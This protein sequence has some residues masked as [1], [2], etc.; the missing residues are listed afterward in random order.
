MNGPFAGE[1]KNKKGKNELEENRKYY[2][3]TDAHENMQTTTKF[4]NC[5]SAD[6]GKMKLH[7]SFCSFKCC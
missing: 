3:R 7:A 1:K 4:H 5:Y 2:N 6:V